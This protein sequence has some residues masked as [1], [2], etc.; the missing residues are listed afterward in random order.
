[1]REN[2]E[3]DRIDVK[4][5]LWKNITFRPTRPISPR[6]PGADPT[7][8]PG[9]I[10]IPSIERAKL[11]SRNQTEREGGSERE[12]GER[13]RGEEEWMR[14]LQK[15]LVSE[16]RG[17]AQ[18]HWR[19]EFNYTAGMTDTLM[20]GWGSSSNFGNTFPAFLFPR[21]FDRDRLF[22]DSLTC[23]DRIVRSE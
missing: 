8:F 15:R 23:N 2:V 17:F 4:E 7:F 3:M 5:I 16:R 6:L 9:K 19:T 11:I 1:M 20:G 13:S 12:A 18:R 10:L 22:F 21:P 14:Q